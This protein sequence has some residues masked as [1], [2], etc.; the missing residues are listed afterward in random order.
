MDEPVDEGLTIP[1]DYVARMFD[2][3]GRVAVVTGGGSGLGAAISDR[4]CPGRRHGRRRRRQRRRRRGDTGR[5]RR[6]GRHGDDEPPRRHQGGGRCAA[7][8]VVERHGR[9]DIL[10]NSA[11]SAFRSPAEDFPEDKFD[12]I[13]DLNLKGTYLCCQAFGRQ[14]ARPGQG[15]HHQPRAPSARSSAIRWASAYLASKGG[16]L[17]HHPWPRA[18]VARPRRAG[19]RHRPD[20]DGLAADSPGRTTRH[21]SPP[22]SS[23]RACCGRGW[24]CRGSSSGPPSSSPA[25]RPSSSPGTR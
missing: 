7:D 9:V 13:L 25:T 21:R 19:Q 2:L 16:V 6:A 3:R 11:G 8:A 17:R 5:H 20:A 10:V 14:D 23:R 24:V 18:R 15:Q 4:L 1:A 12:F 22:T